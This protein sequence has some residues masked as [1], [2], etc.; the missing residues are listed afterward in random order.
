MLS[1]PT[2]EPEHPEVNWAIRSSWGLGFIAVN[3][4]VALW[5]QVGC[6][7]SKGLSSSIRCPSKFLF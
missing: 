4:C 5:L 6:K 7:D 1:A 3:S 2:K